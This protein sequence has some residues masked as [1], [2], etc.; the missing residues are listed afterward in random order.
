M[1][2]RLFLILNLLLISS[3]FA[4]EPTIL[5][6]QVVSVPKMPVVSRNIIVTADGIDAYYTD[7]DRETPF[8]RVILNGFE[9]DDL[10]PGD[11][12]S[13]VPNDSNEAQEFSGDDLTGKG[14][15][16]QFFGKKAHTMTLECARGWDRTNGAIGPL[17]QEQ[18]K[19]VMKS[20]FTLSDTA[21]PQG[22][23]SDF[24]TKH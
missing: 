23:L 5:S 10:K 9:A 14:N 6:A 18:I 20:Y 21:A 16:L 11:F 24:W 22:F 1:K 13:R 3:A 12:L 4:N 19:S 17:T 15:K 2:T 8:C 7:L